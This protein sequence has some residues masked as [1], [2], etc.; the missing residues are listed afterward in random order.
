MNYYDV[1]GV[2]KTASQ[3]EI[4]RAYRA[5]IKFFHPDVFRE[6]EAVAKIKTQ[7]LNEA[8]AVLSDPTQRALYDSKLN[9]ETASSKQS[10][11]RPQRESAQQP[12]REPPPAYRQHT[13]RPQKSGPDF[14]KLRH[15]AI[16]VLAVT[17]L[18]FIVAELDEQSSSA[19]TMPYD[20]EEYTDKYYVLQ[21][22]DAKRYD[23]TED[24]L[25]PV[26]YR[27]GELIKHP[28]EECLCPLGV[29]VRG[30]K[31]YYVVLNSLD[32]YS[33]DMSF[34]VAPNSYAE[35][36]VPLGEYEIFYATGETWYGPDLKFGPDTQYYQCDDTLRFYKDGKYYQG[37]TLELYLQ[38]NGNL[39]TD[40]IS[41]ANFPD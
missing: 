18:S 39:E 8:Y 10:A 9:H 22:D 2:P 14:R 11:Q 25:S 6:S 31:A 4:R 7:Q 15:V 12:R 33:C 29:E 38:N 36:E 40:Q 27:N 35:V 37:Y 28:S 3:D 1:L 23:D 26:S 19:V 5:Q 24:F 34:M 13:V 41:A 30:N 20:T 32:Y 21:E 16:A 17:F